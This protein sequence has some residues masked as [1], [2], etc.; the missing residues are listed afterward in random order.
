MERLQYYRLMDTRGGNGLF[1]SCTT[2]QGSKF[3]WELPNHYARTNYKLYI[4]FP[5]YVPCRRLSHFE[6][7]VLSEIYKSIMIRMTRDQH[8]DS[9]RLHLF[10]LKDK[11][12]QPLVDYW[13]THTRHIRAHKSKSAEASSQS[14]WRQRQEHQ[15]KWVTVIPTDKWPRPQKAQCEP[16]SMKM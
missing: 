4:K 2:K 1:I 16:K 10:L 14:Q 11:F 9:E 13:H 3:L 5:P 8:F 6:A 12:T 7:F 15:S